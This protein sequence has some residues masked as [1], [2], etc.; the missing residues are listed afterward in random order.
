MASAPAAVH[1][2]TFAREPHVG[3]GP[4]IGH[5]PAGW[6]SAT[7]GGPPSPEA[8]HVPPHQ[9]VVAARGRLGAG[10]ATAVRAA[11]DAAPDV[12]WLILDLADVTSIDN[13]GLSSL[14]TAAWRLA[15]GGRILVLGNVSAALAATLRSSGLHR[16]ALIVPTAADGG[17]PDRARLS[18]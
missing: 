6:T 12:R 15:D 11:A 8:A 7:G 9:L 5:R 2:W 1:R 16:K 13:A 4:E 10:I 14:H 18:W 3:P 17:S